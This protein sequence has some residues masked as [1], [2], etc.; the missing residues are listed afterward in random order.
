MKKDIFIILP[1]KESLNPNLAGAVSLYVKDSTKYSKFKKRIQIISSD[2]LKGRSKIFRNKN[3]IINFCK[4]YKNNKIKIIEIHN[5]PEYLYYIKKFFPN[6]KINIIFHNDPLSIRGSIKKDEREKIISNSNKVIFISRWIQ[7]RF[8]SEI[9][10]SNLSNTVIIPHGVN[11]IKN[12]NQ[13]QKKKNI[14]FVA[15]LNDAKGYNIFCDAAKKFKKYNSSWN[16]IAIGNESRK[17][18][19]PDP[20]VVK[21]IGYKKN[22]EVLNYYK[23][24][25]V[26]VGNSVWDEPLGRIAIEASSRKCLP[27]ISNKGGLEESKNIA[28]VLKK[29]NPDV[30]YEV[31]KKV[32][33]DKKYRR[34]KQNLFYKNNNFDLKIISNKLD[35]LRDI[36]LNTEENDQSYQQ[37]RILHIANFNESADGRL[38]YSFAHKLNNGFIKNNYIVQ[39]ISD[40]FF[41]KLNRSFLQPFNPTNKF[42][43]KIL[44]TLKNFSPHVLLIGHVFNISQLVYDYCKKNNIK[45]LS[46]FIDSISNEFL[47]GKKR[48]FFF[49]NLEYVDYCFLTSSPKLFKKHKFYK[50]LKF[51]PN[52]V[53][54][55]IDNF[56]NFNDR[57]LEY[58]IFV[59]IS[60]GQNRGILKKGKT[61]E[62]EQ[63]I[64]K[65]IQNL[66]QNKFA[67][68]GVNNFE[69]I[70]GSNYYHYLSK[71]KMALNISRGSYQNKYSSDRISS[72][73]GNGLLVFINKKTNFHNI[74]SNKEVVYYS[75]DEDL[76]KK[77]K[78]YSQHDNARKKIAKLGYMKYHKYMSNI[79]ITKYIMSCIGLEN[80]KKPFWHSY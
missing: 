66:P 60:H 65:L 10:N 13:N 44:N 52:P 47:N 2:D 15:K 72:L 30:L 61:D 23:K 49:N 12:I 11:K 59:A 16:F 4:R 24:S 21:E 27:I 80:N 76:I 31:L 54:A 62:R 38:Y 67:Q 70:W 75:N 22:S 39:T 26:A 28:L 34:S 14:L 53:D 51:I 20:N 41:L 33:K 63:F 9:K 45:I 64:N 57:N 46:W 3:Y 32:T 36:S 29:N 48:S 6:S 69:P 37:K 56:R 5:R 40:R 74:L 50:K 17:K 43:E 58:D 19:F 71:S 79:I 73:I 78:Y 68:F 18:I 35:F 7:Q 55:S 8:F 1:F 25:E 42:N 77:I